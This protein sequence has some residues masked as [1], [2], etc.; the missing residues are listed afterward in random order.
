MGR[1]GDRVRERERERG[2]GREG[3]GRARGTVALPRAGRVQLLSATSLSPK[4]KEQDKEL[5]CGI[6]CREI[7]VDT[8]HPA[9]CERR[10]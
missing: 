3:D 1:E 7:H 4:R 8:V 10:Q 9:A 2:G 5:V 6:R